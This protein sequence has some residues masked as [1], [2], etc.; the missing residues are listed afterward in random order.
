M[1]KM[2]IIVGTTNQGKLKEMQ[3][4]YAKQEITFRS[5]TDY[6]S[7]QILVEETGQTYAENALLKARTYAKELGLPVLADDGGLEIQAFPTILGIKTARFFQ[8]Q[9][10]DSQK[11]QQLLALFD[12]RPVSREMT[13][14]A[15]LA[16]AKPNG[17]YI[18][19]QGKLRGTLAEQ[20]TGELGY[21][22]DKIFYIPELKKTLAQLPEKQR[23]DL[24]PRISALRA[25]IN[26]LKEHGNE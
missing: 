7:K 2:E 22:F 21:G 9:A 4:A 23:N 5:Y 12:Q 1:R 14:Q 13:L 10:T 26:Q 15:T 16:Y 6:T 8:E 17:E 3:S 24:S 11:N 19:T 20:E 18:L 25:M